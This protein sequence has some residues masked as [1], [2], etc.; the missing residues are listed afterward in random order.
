MNEIFIAGQNYK[1]MKKD[2]KSNKNDKSYVFSDCTLFTKENEM[3]F[4]ICTISVVVRLI[5]FYYKLI[6]MRKYFL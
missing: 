6:G 1:S 4:D 5:I 2:N 3:S